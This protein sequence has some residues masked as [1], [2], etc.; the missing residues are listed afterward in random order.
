MFKL[1]FYINN[2]SICEFYIVKV[3]I[4]L[5]LLKDNQNIFL[6]IMFL[7]WHILNSLAC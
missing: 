5:S 4:T 7:K 2:S 6:F 1:Y 3:V